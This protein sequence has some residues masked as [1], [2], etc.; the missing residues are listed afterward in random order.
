L[1]ANSALFSEYFLSEELEVLAV[2]ATENLQAS[3][4]LRG[5]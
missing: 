4:L 5:K 1:V 3:D 2:K